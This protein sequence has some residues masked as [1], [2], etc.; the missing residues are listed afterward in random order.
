MQLSRGRPPPPPP[1]LLLPTPPLVSQQALPRYLLLQQP[2]EQRLLP[3]VALRQTL[4]RLQAWP[5]FP[6]SDPSL[7]PLR[8]PVPPPRLLPQADPLL[9]LPAP[10]HML[11]SSR[12][13]DQCSRHLPRLVL[14]PAP[15]SVLTVA[16]LLRPPRQ[17]V[18]R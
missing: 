16:H 1:P 2:L 11:R 6:S 5:S 9:P 7:M 10:L 3:S 4:A 8:Q 17:E 14:L 12:M 13:A 18:Q 15:L